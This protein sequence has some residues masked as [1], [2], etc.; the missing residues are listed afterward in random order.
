MSCTKWPPDEMLPPSNLPRDI[1]AIDP[2]IAEFLGK[3]TK[4]AKSL[5]AE[6]LQTDVPNLTPLVDRLAEYVP[7]Q[8][9]FSNGIGYV[10]CVRRGIDGNGEAF[11]SIL[12]AQ[13]LS[14]EDLNKRLEYFDDSMR[15]LMKEFLSRFAGCGEE[16]EE[17]MAGQFCFLKA[18]LASDFNSRDDDSYGDWRNGLR[19][20]AALNGDSVFIDEHGATAWH[21]IE[22]DEILPIADNF[23]D[24]IKAHADFRS[25]SGV[26]DS[27]A[28]REFATKNSR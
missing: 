21:V 18:P 9:M 7:Y 14:S 11:D 27:W 5:M 25:T 15:P 26:F 19:L 3:D 23:G 28:W 2:W 20:Y 8:V 12:I 10:R 17:E 16:M 4:T 22:T 1:D 13:P 24:F 6:R